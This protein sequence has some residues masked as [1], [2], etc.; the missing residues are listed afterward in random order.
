[1]GQPIHMQTK[2]IELRFWILVAIIVT[3]IAVGN[4]IISKHYADKI[5]D[6]FRVTMAEASETKALEVKKNTPTT[7]E[8]LIVSSALRHGVSAEK[9]LRVARCESNFNTQAIGDG[10]RAYGV[11]QYHGPTF[12]SFS[13]LYGVTYDYRSPTDQIDL[14][15]WAFSQGLDT[16]WTCK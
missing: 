12:Q 1:M 2:H 7:V 6:E 13:N 14:T 10:G 16:H 3:V 9:M 11:Y 15:G 4:Y 5:I 8:G